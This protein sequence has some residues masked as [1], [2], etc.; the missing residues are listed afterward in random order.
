M[1]K[2][3]NTLFIVLFLSNFS[4]SAQYV[5]TKADSAQSASDYRLAIDLFYQQGNV[6]DNLLNLVIDYAHLGFPDSAIYFLKRQKELWGLPISILSVPGFC[7]IHENPEWQEIAS[8]LEKEYF[9]ANPGLNKD[10]IKMLWPM[11]ID[12]QFYRDEYDLYVRKYGKNSNELDSID[13]LQER[14]DSINLVKLENI[15]TK[16]GWP[17]SSEVG[18]GMTVAIPFFIIQHTK[19]LAVQKK[20]LPIIEGM[21][22]INE[23]DPAS[24]AY[25]SDRI[26]ASEGKK[27]LYG[28]QVQQNKENGKN[29]VCPIEDEENVDKRRAD[30]GMGPLKDYLIMFGIEY[31]NK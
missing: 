8:T 24:F 22:K 29:E 4:I 2:I 16:Y 9:E 26:L 11:G 18:G 13:K 12:D 1:H 7:A 6:D 14:L 10:L 31:E 15:V 19:D 25:L 30:F 21:V 17:K 3:K 23:A 28:T 20:Y 5:F 27:Q